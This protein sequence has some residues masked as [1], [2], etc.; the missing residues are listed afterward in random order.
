VL[1]KTNVLQSIFEAALETYGLDCLIAAMLN[2][3]YQWVVVKQTDF[4][5]LH[6]INPRIIWRGP[7]MSRVEETSAL[8]VDVAP[9]NV[10]RHHNIRVKYLTIKGG[11]SIIQLE[12]I[13]SHC[14]QSAT[15]DLFKG[16]TLHNRYDNEDG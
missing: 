15:V 12:G 11:E 3:P 13:T 7:Q 14:L 16:F 1:E 8:F 6:M 10:T 5:I 2:R 9:V 4:D